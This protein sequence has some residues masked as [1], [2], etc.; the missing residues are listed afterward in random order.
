MSRVRSSRRMFAAAAI[1]AVVLLGACGGG[2]HAVR[3]GAATDAASYTFDYVI[4]AGSAARSKAGEHLLIFPSVLRAKV[5]DTVRIVNEDT[6]VHEVGPFTV[7]P[8]QTLTQSFISEGTYEGVCT[9]HPGSTFK[10][11]VTAD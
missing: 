3:T 11:V 2:G 1:A 10:V 6:E 9:T 4:P 8:G 5:G 7:A